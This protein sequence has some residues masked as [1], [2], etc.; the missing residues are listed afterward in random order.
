VGIT[1]RWA[2]GWLSWVY[3][4]APDF[5][6]ALPEHCLCYGRNQL[7]PSLTLLPCGPHEVTPLALATATL[8]ARRERRK[9][10]SW[11]PVPQVRSWC[12]SSM[13]A[14][15]LPSDLK[16][17]VDMIDDDYRWLTNLRDVEGSGGGLF[18]YTEWT[19]LNGFIFFDITKRHTE[20][21][22]PP[23]E[24]EFN[25]C[26]MLERWHNSIDGH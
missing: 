12:C 15:F 17:A 4:W 2:G 26:S 1:I 6:L 9:L 20:M 8:A 10:C 23:L 5:L 19:L 25:F 14:N 3:G 13:H 11:L 24:G 16:W 21:E 7:I 22:L 18:Q